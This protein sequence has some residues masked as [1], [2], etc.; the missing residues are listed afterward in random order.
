M[1]I[2][3]DGLPVLG[4][5]SKDTALVGY[6]CFKGTKFVREVTAAVEVITD[7]FS[8]NSTKLE[9][10]SYTGEIDFLA[11]EMGVRWEVLDDIELG[12]LN[13]LW[14]NPVMLRRL[15][16]DTFIRVDEVLTNKL[17]REGNGLNA[18]S[19]A[20]KS[21]QECVDIIARDIKTR[22]DL[23]AS[24]STVDFLDILRSPKANDPDKRILVPHHLID[25]TEKTDEE[26]A[27]FERFRLSRIG[28]RTLEEGDVEIVQALAA[29]VAEEVGKLEIFT[30]TYSSS[31]TNFSLIIQRRFRADCGDIYD[32][33]CFTPHQVRDK[34]YSPPHPWSS[35]VEL[36]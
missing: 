6:F 8:R 21:F 2:G 17:L 9:D 14:M 22:Q 28:K 4:P 12:K 3:P 32:E 30:Y 34:K 36:E 19:F 13:L 1:K 33:D 23:F 16:K 29:R 24:L 11:K 5:Y 7:G 10:M 35:M 25:E 18:P 15:P 20:G 27:A 31:I 26:F